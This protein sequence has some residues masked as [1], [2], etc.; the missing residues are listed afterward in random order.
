M[1]GS[2]TTTWP[3]CASRTIGAAGGAVRASPRTP[4]DRGAARTTA[5]DIR[6]R[7]HHGSRQERTVPDRYAGLLVVPRPTTTLPVPEATCPEI[8]VRPGAAGGRCPEPATVPAGSAHGSSC[9]GRVRSAAP[10]A[11]PSGTSHREPRPASRWCRGG[12]RRRAGPPTAEITHAGEAGP[13]AFAAAGRRPAIRRTYRTCTNDDTPYTRQ[14][15]RF[16]VPATP[17]LTTEYAGER[18]PKPLVLFSL[19]PRE[20]GADHLV[21]VAEWQTR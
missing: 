19:S 20:T 10:R 6:H 7:T 13:M 2:A 1:R 11:L 15:S 12:P 14:A 21:R 4:G 3:R 17:S 5:G 8:T 18:H 16:R 9:L